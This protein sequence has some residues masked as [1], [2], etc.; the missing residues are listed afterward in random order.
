MEFD[1]LGV[2]AII[3][4]IIL[5]IG[6]IIWLLSG[7]N[8]T[9]KIDVTKNNNQAAVELL[10]AIK[11]DKGK[12]IVKKKGILE[13]FINDNRLTNII[14]QP[15]KF[16]KQKFDERRQEKDQERKEEKEEREEKREKK[17]EERRE[18]KKEPFKRVS[19]ITYTPKNRFIKQNDDY[20]YEW[21]KKLSD[22]IRGIGRGERICKAALEDIFQITFKKIRPSWLKNPKTGRHL[23]IDCYAKLSNGKE[24][25]LEYQGDQHTEWQENK[26]RFFKTEEEFI[27]QLSKDSF[28]KERILKRGAY[29]IEVHHKIKYK[30]I[31]LFIL[32][33]L[34]EK[35]IL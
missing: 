17:R 13:D 5:V 29:F 6:I 1:K 35:G 11:N 30:D 28:K 4:I 14:P 2:A 34:R 8:K 19:N 25:A 21:S 31:G 24:I 20:E 27:Y 33:E 32:D 3:F 26:S 18:E 10:K 15:L 23:E 9:N 7:K 16:I 22:N 12:E